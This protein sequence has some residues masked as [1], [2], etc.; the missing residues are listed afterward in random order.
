MK[1]MWLSRRFTFILPP[2]SFIP[3][4]WR[5]S[6]VVRQRSAKP[7][8]IGSIPIAA[9]NLIF[10]SN[11]PNIGDSID[12][13]GQPPPVL[14]AQYSGMTTRQLLLKPCCRHRAPQQ[15]GDATG[16]I[17]DTDQTLDA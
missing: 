15:A 6:Q 2:S 8:F 10:S 3:F 1:A 13:G 4:L 16:T 11:W 7:L 14:L 17:S 9:S 12:P 5:R